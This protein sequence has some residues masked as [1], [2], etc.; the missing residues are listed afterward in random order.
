MLTWPK[1]LVL[2]I[3]IGVAMLYGYRAMPWSCMDATVTAYWVQAIVSMIAICVA[4]YVANSQ[5]IRENRRQ[6]EALIR[7]LARS[8]TMAQAIAQ[9][10]GEAIH[11]VGAAL[12]DL[13]FPNSRVSLLRLNRAQHLLELLMLQ[14]HPNTLTESLAALFALCNKTES[15]CSDVFADPNEY[16][17]AATGRDIIALEDEFWENNKE[18]R[19]LAHDAKKKMSL[20]GEHQRPA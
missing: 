7:D 11:C 4:L 1:M 2:V 20:F 17:A 3:T 18:I 9:Q 16:Y 12:Q 10:I 14:P 15:M 6:Q 13:D 5:A 8:T 19:I